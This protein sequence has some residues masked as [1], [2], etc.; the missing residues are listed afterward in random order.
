LLAIIKHNFLG[1]LFCDYL[2]CQSLNTLGVPRTHGINPT[3]FYTSKS[4][5]F[6]PNLFHHLRLQ[7]TTAEIHD[8]LQG[9]EQNQKT[10]PT[11]P[12]IWHR[13]LV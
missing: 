13:L 3:S 11:N 1:E 5:L 12:P 8:S 2:I 9:D 10:D 4:E 6:L 7:M